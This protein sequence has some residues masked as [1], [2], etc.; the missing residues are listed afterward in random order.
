MKKKRA[1]ENNSTFLIS[2]HKPDTG[3]SNRTNE[4]RRLP[5]IFLSQ[6]L[7]KLIKGEQSKIIKVKKQTNYADRN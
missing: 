5:V 6:I 4:N 2:P 7:P 3:N 1:K